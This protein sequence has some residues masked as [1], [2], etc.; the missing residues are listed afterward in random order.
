MKLTRPSD[1]K[2]LLKER[3]IRPSRFMGQ[4][5]L[6]DE[7]IL[8]IILGAARLQP[9]DTVLEIGPGLGVLTEPMLMEAGRVIA[10]EKDPDF[11][12]YLRQRFADA[13]NFKLIESDVMDADLP[14][15]FERGTDKIVANLPYGVG[16][17]LLVDI[18]DCA[19]R[20]PEMVIMLQL[21]V[22]RRLNAG[23]GSK[24]YGFLSIRIQ[25]DYEVN[26]L[27]TVNRT[28]FYPPPHVQSAILSL[29]SRKNSLADVSDRKFFFLL[30]KQCFS[31]RRKQIG[32]ILRSKATELGLR[33]DQ[34]DADLVSTSISPETRPEEISISSW[35]S[36]SNR[37]I[38]GL[39]Q[40][41]TTRN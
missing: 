29:K 32:H 17:R 15:L 28:C 12:K 34:L 30:L 4:N 21:D 41:Q 23:P 18:A 2:R 35:V 14:S 40:G 3:R 5:F 25:L 19:V 7:N 13:A 31:Q 20:P 36:L 37:L 10:I 1:V 16:S 27:K 8:K 38:Q 22:A 33:A 26:L 11:C 6:I 39:M 24:E 9:G